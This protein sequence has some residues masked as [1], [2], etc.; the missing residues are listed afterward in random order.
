MDYAIVLGRFDNASAKEQSMSAVNQTPQHAFRDAL[1]AFAT[2]VTIVTTMDD[3]A[4]DGAD[5]NPM[6]I[7][8]TAS[9]FN[10]VSLDPPLV[11]WSLSKKSLSHPV[12]CNSGHFA[13]HILASDQAALA[14]QFARQH[15]DKWA[16][17]TWHKGVLGSPL[18]DDHTAVF[19][20][21][22]RHQ[23]D[24]GDHVILVG[25]VVE[26][27]TRQKPPLL[28]HGGQYSE[29]RTRPD[30]SLTGGAAKDANTPSVLDMTEYAGFLAHYAGDRPAL[31]A[32]LQEAFNA[33]Q[34]DHA[35]AV[36]KHLIA[37]IAHPQDSE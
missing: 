7:G 20:C 22:T 24:G 21:R 13:I 17:V 36:L 37:S 35:K 3:G 12:F 25:E 28:F 11:L 4:D 15:T 34:I 6:P 2:G 26:Y 32:E 14:N 33:D 8:V 27:E 23:Y 1:G 18:I 16:G 5:G 19:E 10:S 29:S 31:E 9:S 30:L